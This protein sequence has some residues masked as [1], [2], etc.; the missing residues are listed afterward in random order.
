MQVR[1]S[2]L[3]LVWV[4]CG[5]AAVLST[6]HAAQAL[7]AARPLA[8][9]PLQREGEGPAQIGSTLPLSLALVGALAALA[10][11]AVKWK[12]RSINRHSVDG[13]AQARQSMRLT[14]GTSL[15][16][17]QWGAEE[18]L[19]AC[20]AHGTTVLSRRTLPPSELSDSVRAKSL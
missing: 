10:V 11:V 20:T 15:H 7:D 12:Q 18:M 16:V 6:A 13:A 5:A 1:R 17:I 9:L 2:F 19:L 14:S 3:V 4:A 8:H